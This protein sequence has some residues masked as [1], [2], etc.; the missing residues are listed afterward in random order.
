MIRS[1]GSIAIARVSLGSIIRPS[2]M[3]QRSVK[4][5]IAHRGSAKQRDA[6]GLDSAIQVLVIDGVFIMPDPSDRPGHLG[7]N[8]RA[9]IHSLGGL[10]GIDG[11]AGPRVDRR[12]HA[13]SGTDRREGEARCSSDAEAAIG[14]VVVHVALP[15]MHL[16]PG[17][18]MRRNVLRFGVVGRTR[19]QGRAQIV[20]L[21]KKSVRNA[22]VRIAG[23]ARGT[24][25]IG[26][27]VRVH[28]GT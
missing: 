20:A 11:R 3:I 8:E 22:G 1:P 14:S 26:A 17:I 5:K 19:I 16:A 18:L 10:D 23:V 4:T 27:G 24:R 13:H 28:P 15:G 6:E 12:S 21:D 7:G 2:R 9:A 25:R